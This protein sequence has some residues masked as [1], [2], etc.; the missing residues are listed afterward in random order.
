LVVGKVVSV[1]A[2]TLTSSGVPLGVSLAGDKALDGVDVEVVSGIA[3]A[4]SV[5]VDEAVGGAEV[6]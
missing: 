1:V 3:L 2:L 4:L 6:A 5:G